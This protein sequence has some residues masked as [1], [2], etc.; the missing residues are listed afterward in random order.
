[1]SSKVARIVQQ[2][3]LTGQTSDLA[4]AITFT[5]PSGG[6]DYRVSAYASITAGHTNSP[7][8]VTINWT[9]DVGAQSAGFSIQNGTSGGVLVSGAKDVVI[10]AASGTTVSVS[11]VNTQNVG[12]ATYSL[13]AT[14][15]EL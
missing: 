3:S 1:M 6:A 7:G 2:V 10:H 15:E 13:Y 8:S 12:S 9:D 11:T 5:A 4:T 14:L